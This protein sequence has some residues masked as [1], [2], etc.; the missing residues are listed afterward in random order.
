MASEDADQELQVIGACT[1]DSKVWWGPTGIH[2]ESGRRYLLTASGHWWDTTI[3]CGPEGY[4]LS[5]VPWWKRPI[6][7]ASGWLRP[8]GGQVRW[9]ALL[10]RIGLRGDVFL[11][12]KELDLVIASSGQLYCTVNDISF[13][14]YNNR[15]TV[16]LVVSREVEQ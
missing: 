11:I 5:G 4:D 3:C 15:G 8:L 6:F 16:E 1:V 7:R 2:I 9:F 10:G 12:A 14:H 13:M